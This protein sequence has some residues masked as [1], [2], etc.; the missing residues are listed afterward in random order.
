MALSQQTHFL[1]C[2]SLFY[3]LDRVY[4]LGG[5]N[6]VAI[7]LIVQHVHSQLEEVN[8]LP[9]KMPT[10]PYKQIGTDTLPV[11]IAKNENTGN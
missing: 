10:Q 5:G 1:T 4:G 7:D 6:M 9:V 3:F 8:T 11:T 2:W